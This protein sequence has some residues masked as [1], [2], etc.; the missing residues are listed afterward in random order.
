MRWIA[1]AAVA[2]LAGC[3]LPGRFADRARAICTD[4]GLQP[5]TPAFEQCFN[6]TFATIYPR[7]PGAQAVAR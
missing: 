3:D 1:L 4:N 7:A 6:T 5:G 2:L